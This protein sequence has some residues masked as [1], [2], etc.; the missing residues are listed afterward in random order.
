L[1]FDLS[2]PIEI[3]IFDL[4]FL[5]QMEFDHYCRPFL[6]CEHAATQPTNNNNTHSV[7]DWNV[8]ILVKIECLHVFE[9][10]YHCYREKHAHIPARAGMITCL[11]FHRHPG[12]G[13]PA[14]FARVGWDFTP[15]WSSS[16]G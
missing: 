9:N 7:T 14:R 1:L 10:A 16:P 11:L 15:G 6:F 8:F 2:Y 12:L 3:W 4:L 13:I 5:L